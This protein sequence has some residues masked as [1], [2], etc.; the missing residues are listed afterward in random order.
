MLGLPEVL[1]IIA[2]FIAIIVTLVGILAHT[3]AQRFAEL[4]ERLSVMAT[5]V[6]DFKMRGSLP[7]TDIVNRLGRIEHRLDRM[8]NG[9]Y[10]K[11]IE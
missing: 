5:L 6:D 3:A 10:K 1:G 11:G 2:I 9:T 7:V 4:S 8:E